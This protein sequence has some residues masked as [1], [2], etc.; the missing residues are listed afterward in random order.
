MEYNPYNLKLLEEKPNGYLDT[1]GF[2]NFLIKKNIS[3]RKDNL[4]KF[5]FNHNI[6]M[7]KFKREGSGGM[8]PTAY[9]IPTLAKIEEIKRVMFLSNNNSLGKKNIE[10][11]EKKI[12]EIFDKAENKIESKSSI[13]EKVSVFLGVPC[14]R[15][16]V[17]RVLN[18]KRSSKLNKLR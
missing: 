15:K 4:P 3:V 17:R 2:L 10:N 8:V 7:C 1:D 18:E 5:S 16:L 13:A 12:L 9:K 6:Q 11:K 14:N